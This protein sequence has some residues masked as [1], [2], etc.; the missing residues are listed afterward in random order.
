L[1]QLVELVVGQ[2]NEGFE[3]ENADRHG[4]NQ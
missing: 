2:V 3:V 4:V 1:T